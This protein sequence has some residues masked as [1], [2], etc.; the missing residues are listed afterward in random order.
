MNI[1]Q[2]KSDD[3]F[4]PLFESEGIQSPSPD[5]TNNIISKINAVES[6]K[7]QTSN[8]K[9]PLYIWLLSLLGV[10][11]AITTLIWLS[12]YGYIQLI[13]ENF[14]F[15]LIPMFK[16]VV[17]SFKEIFASISISSTTVAIVA[18]LTIL[19]VFERILKFTAIGKNNY[20]FTL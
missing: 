16:S 9:Y 19:I 4:R 11:I 1:E 5:F 12:N 17:F 20:L 15:V 13:P 3:I 18:A 7:V 6:I 8:Q 14:E 2:N 10:A